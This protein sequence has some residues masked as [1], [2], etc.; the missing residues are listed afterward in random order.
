[1]GAAPVAR[2]ADVCAGPNDHLALSTRLIQTELMIAALSCGASPRYNTFVR[3]FQSGLALQNRRVGQ[4]FQRVSGTGGPRATNE[5]VTRTANEL[6]EKSLR[7][8]ND[9]CTAA[10]QTFDR[11]DQA[12]PK[13]LEN[14]VRTHPLHAQPVV[15]VCA[16]PSPSGTEAKL[17]RPKKTPPA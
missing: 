8:I 12:S 15:Q 9:F 17:A 3:K 14:F 16:Q 6:S 10:A 4:Y 7:E 5:F 11:A 1:M 13:E 2:A